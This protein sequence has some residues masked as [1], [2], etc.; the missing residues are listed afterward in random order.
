MNQGDVRQ[1]ANSA[2]QLAN[3]AQD[4]RRALQQ[5]G[6]D[7][8]DLQPVDEVVKALRALGDEKSYTNPQNLQQLLSTAS[9]RFKALEFE[10]RKRMDTTNEQL[11]LS[12]SDEVPPNFRA[13]IDQYYRTLSNQKK[14]AGKGGGK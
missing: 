12:G 9:D 1:W 8:K 5:G 10:L 2:R 6:V 3:D 11:F 7:G 4:L 13:L 14:P